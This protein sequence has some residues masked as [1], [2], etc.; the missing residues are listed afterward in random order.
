MILRFCLSF[1]IQGYNFLY[2]GLRIL[3]GRELN[4]LRILEGRELNYLCSLWR[5]FAYES[6]NGHVNQSKA[7]V[8]GLDYVLGYL[9]AIGHGCE[10]QDYVNYAELTVSV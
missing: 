7:R 5:G 10:A 4:R 6:L 1:F 3:E 9:E 8:L 2:D